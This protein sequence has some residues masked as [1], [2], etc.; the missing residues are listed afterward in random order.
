MPQEIWIAMGV[1]SAVGCNIGI[2][3]IYWLLRSRL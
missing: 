2:W 1:G 3:A